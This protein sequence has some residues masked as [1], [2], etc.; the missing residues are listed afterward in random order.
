MVDKIVMLEIKDMVNLVNTEQLAN[1]EGIKVNVDMA[2]NVENYQ[3]WY[4]HIHVIPKLNKSI[5]QNITN[6]NLH[7]SAIQACFLSAKQTQMLNPALF[8][9][10]ICFT[11]IIISNTKPNQNMSYMIIFARM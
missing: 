6:P 2:D 7:C 10:E 3:I 1:M 5:K 9:S 8:M 4:I 11:P